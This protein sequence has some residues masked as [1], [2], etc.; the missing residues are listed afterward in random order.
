MLRP[1]EATMTAADRALVAIALVLL[2]AAVSLV[3]DY[4]TQDPMLVALQIN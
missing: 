1:T 3:V 2:V 4:T